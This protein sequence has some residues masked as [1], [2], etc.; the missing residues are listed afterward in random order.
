MVETFSPWLAAWIRPK[1]GGGCTSKL[2][3]QR[4]CK[5]TPQ[6][7]STRYFCLQV[8]VYTPFFLNI[9][10]PASEEYYIGLQYSTFMS[11]TSMVTRCGEPGT[12]S[13]HTDKIKQ[14]IANQLLS[15][16]SESSDRFSKNIPLGTLCII[17]V[18]LYPNFHRWQQSA[19]TKINDLHGEWASMR[20]I[21][22]GNPFPHCSTY[23]FYHPRI[24]IDLSY[25]RLE[26]HLTRY[27]YREFHVWLAHELDSNTYDKQFSMRS[28]LG[29]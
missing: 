3:L 22:L 18:Y 21:C 8:W 9:S 6:P 20:D 28:P 17:S 14:S 12:V 24:R 25:H 26:W 13:Y 11:N 10:S 27:G 2:Q 29:P 4:S 19:K 7:V 16:L 15:L 23:K 5:C 1:S